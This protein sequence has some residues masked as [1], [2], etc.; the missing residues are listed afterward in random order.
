MEVVSKDKE[1]G[2]KKAAKYCKNGNHLDI[3]T[4]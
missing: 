1:L 2:E 4:D 3:N